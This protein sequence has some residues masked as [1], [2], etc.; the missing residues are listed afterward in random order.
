M[1]K[2]S[3]T[4]ALLAPWLLLV[5]GF[6]PAA[7]SQD[8]SPIARAM[9]DIQESLKKL[10]ASLDDEA[11][12]AA[13]WPEVCRL[14]RVVLDA[15]DA[16]PSTVTELEDEKKRDKQTIAF[17]LEMQGL[18]RGFL[19]LEA[20]VLEG[21]EKDVKKALRGFE[22]LKSAGHSEFKPRR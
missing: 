13:A 20:A 11:N 2:L 14:Q 1:K 15:K 8:D 12:L 21:K 5:A 10:E 9:G 7:P 6:V 18:L 22:K 16:L 3:L 19:D 17:R 4:L